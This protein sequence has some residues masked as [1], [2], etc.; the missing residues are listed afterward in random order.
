MPLAAENLQHGASD[1]KFVAHGQRSE[2]EKRSGHVEGRREEA[3]F[4]GAAAALGIE[5]DEFVEEFY[6]VGGANAAIEIGEIGAATESYVLAIIDVL[7]IGQN[8]GGGAA[9]EKRFLFEQPNAPAC[10]S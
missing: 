9:T 2:G 8:I 6:F 4:H 3:G 5:E 7:A 1:G 10:F